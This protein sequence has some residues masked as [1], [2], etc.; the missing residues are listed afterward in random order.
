MMVL[1]R[2][3]M[4][5]IPGVHFLGLIIAVSTIT[6]RSKA[7]IPLYVYIL[8]DGLIVGFS[9][10][11]IPYL[12]IWLPLWLMFMLAGRLKLRK[13]IKTPLYMT[14]CAL[15]GLSF[16]LLYAPMQTLFFGL[17]FEGTVAWVIAGLPTDITHA[18]SNFVMGSLIIP[19]SALL[20]KLDKSRT[21][22][23]GG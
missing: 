9:Q 20:R 21:F 10:W 1:S 18:V 8:T 13:E 4:Q 12:Y 23:E 17:S 6:Y 14:L 3:L 2:N 5:L 15:H 19:L 16:G 7:L 11:W 22:K